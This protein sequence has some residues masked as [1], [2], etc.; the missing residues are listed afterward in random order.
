MTVVT[1]TKMQVSTM[2]ETCVGKSVKVMNI[3]HQDGTVSM[4]TLVSVI[5]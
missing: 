2:M 1:V 3:G 5:M 4:V